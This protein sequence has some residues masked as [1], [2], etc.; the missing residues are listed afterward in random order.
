MDGLGIGLLIFGLFFIISG[1]VEACYKQKKIH[2]NDINV[3]D[4]IVIKGEKFIVKGYSSSGNVEISRINNAS[5][6]YIININPNDILVSHNE[7]G[8]R[9]YIS[10]DNFKGTVGGSYLDKIK[11]E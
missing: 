3:G 4:K 7:D 5:E 1:I 10:I 8:E 9:K 2:L 6:R 11:F